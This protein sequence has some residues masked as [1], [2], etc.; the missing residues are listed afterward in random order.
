MKYFI[1]RRLISSVGLIFGITCFTFL[2]MHCC[3]GDF[4]TQVEADPSIASKYVLSLKN[5]F[6]LDKPW[7]VQYFCW[8]K[9]LCRLDFGESWIYNLPVLKLFQQRVWATIRLTSLALVLGWISAIPCAIL[10]AIYAHGWWDKAMRF[11]A[12]LFLSLPEFFLALLGIC[13]A[14]KTGLL[15]IMGK[16]SIEHDFLTP[17]QQIVDTLQHLLLPACI[18][19]LGIF[20]H[21]FRITRNC[22]LDNLHAEYVRA[23]QAKGVSART[24]L[25]KHVLRNTFNPLIS[26]FGFALAGLLSGALLVE[27]IFN[28][29]GLGQLLFEAF[30]AKD[31]YVVMGAVVMGS[32][33][34]ISGNLLAD[35]LLCFNDP[36]LRTTLR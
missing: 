7:Y 1:G 33:M 18:L 28:Y 21:I 17:S 16:T 8:V 12:Y 20:A 36:R 31:Q 15:P 30:M 19:S 13:F 32:G 14:A 23:A 11:L 3:P 35:V 2:L 5:K 25:F 10:A 27:N 4:L 24:L 6:G 34:L 29:P 26:H 22:Y 9:C